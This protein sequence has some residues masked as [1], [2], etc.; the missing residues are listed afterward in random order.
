VLSL[1]YYQRSWAESWNSCFQKCTRNSGCGFLYN[2]T[3]PYQHSPSV[4]WQLVSAICDDGDV[5]IHCECRHKVMSY[6][7]THSSYGHFGFAGTG[8]MVTCEVSLWSF[9]SILIDLQSAPI[10]LCSICN[11]MPGICNATLF[12]LL[13][14]LNF[15]GF[16]WKLSWQEIIHWENFDGFV[17]KLSWQEIICGENSITTTF[18]AEC[19]LSKKFMASYSSL[20]CIGRK[21]NHYHVLMFT[22]WF[23]L[24]IAKWFCDSV[25]FPM[26]Q[27]LFNKWMQ[28][29]WEDF[30]YVH[31]K[32]I[33]ESLW[34][35]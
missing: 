11:Q 30:G 2:C 6:D 5:L 3:T 24:C 31:F 25:N 34:R 21:Q 13:V 35:S 27:T 28:I 29:E 26:N 10:S 19:S 14:T 7:C 12:H 16:V 33:K 4:G 17:W 1:D 18:V 8:T 15:D 23:S 9:L 32:L 20:L 22:R